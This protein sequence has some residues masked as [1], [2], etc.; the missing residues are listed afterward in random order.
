[1][2]DDP[3]PRVCRHCRQIG[4]RR[5]ED[6]DEVVITISS[7]RLCYGALHNVWHGAS[8]PP[9]QGL[10]KIRSKTSGTVV[11]HRAEFNVA[12]RNGAWNAFQLVD[13][14]HNKLTAWFLA[15]SDVDAEKEIDKILRVSGSPYER[16]SG[17]SMNDDKTEAE[18]ILVINRY[19][20][21]WYDNRGKDEVGG[22]GENEEGA[23]MIRTGESVGIVDFAGA[24]PNV[25]RW[26]EEQR[27]DA[28]EWSEGAAWL[29]I[30]GGEYAFGRFGFDD[31]RIAARSFLF[32]TTNTYFTRTAFAG[33][34]QPLKIE[35]TD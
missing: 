21:G 23:I 35:E 1:M 14:E 11:V 2:V 32:F 15:H 17:S 12:A 31:D 8:A 9:V 30:P 25:L 13:L 33:F 28:R 24:K 5:E 19:D 7:G 29:H 3:H 26:K 4:R 16:D 34:D 22:D 6:A 10:P 20:W 18:G 27:P